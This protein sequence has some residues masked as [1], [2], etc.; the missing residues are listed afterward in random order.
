MSACKL[1]SCGFYSKQEQIF[2]IQ[3]A[4]QPLFSNLDKS[5][6]LYPFKRCWG[7][8][9]FSHCY[10]NYKLI[11]LMGIN[12]SK[13][14]VYELLVAVKK[15]LQAKLILCVIP[16]LYICK[17][18]GFIKGNRMFGNGN[19][20]QN[21]LVLLLVL[22][23]KY[24]YSYQC[25]RTQP[26]PMYSYPAITNVL[27]L[28]HHQCTRTQPSPMYSY[29]S[30]TNV[31]VLSHHQCTRTQPSPMYSYSSITNVL[32]LSHHQC[33]RTQPSPMYSYSAI[34]N[35]CTRTHPSP[36]YSYSAITNVLVLIHHQCSY[37]AITNVLVLSHHQLVLVLALM[38]MHSVPGLLARNHFML[39]T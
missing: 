17:R 35:Q 24:S 26:S 23:R 16:C 32:V 2:L 20:I 11:G 18:E 34:T 36:M 30:I 4:T 7:G 14:V 9:M 3:I 31:L 13:H 5:S 33:T 27:V 8:A 37:S 28:S 29:S 25:T 6:H 39:R 38:K 15:G 10:A 22:V 1:V 19:V 12:I 21:V